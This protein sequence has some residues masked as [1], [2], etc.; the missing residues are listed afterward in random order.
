M[1][2]VIITNNSAIIAVDIQNDFCPGGAL[3]VPDGDAVVY[4]MN[5][6]ITKF[7]KMGL[8][9]YFTRDWHPQNHIS[10]KTNGGIWP[11]HCVQETYGAEL[12]KKLLIPSRAVIISKG[13]SPDNDGYSGFEETDLD[14]R[15]K[16]KNIRQ[17]FIGGLATDY[18]VKST[19]LDALHAGFD[20]VF[21]SD[22]SKGV[23]VNT[24]DS[25]QA[26]DEMLRE[27]AVKVVY[28]DIRWQ[29]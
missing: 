10:F 7:S 15:L 24:G 4:S 5:L 2:R 13:I 27:G 12:H 11:E 22:A 17:L 6:Y 25:E 3:P 9:V 21:L 1:N 26:I 14:K 20:V 28:G 29:H 18:C 16:A 8:P 23:D 19:V